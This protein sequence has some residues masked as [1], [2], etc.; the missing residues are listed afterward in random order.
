MKLQWSHDINLEISSLGSNLTVLKT[1]GFAWTSYKSSLGR[2]NIPAVYGSLEMSSN[3]AGIVAW[4]SPVLLR[5]QDGSKSKNS[6]CSSPS[7]KYCQWVA[8]VAGIPYLIHSFVASWWSR[9]V[10]YKNQTDSFSLTS[11][12]NLFFLSKY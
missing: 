5:V 2:C 3:M 1:G 9:K 8:Q 10:I 12:Q 4:S 7:N 11:L 6:F